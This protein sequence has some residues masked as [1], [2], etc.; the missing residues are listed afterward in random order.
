MT[1]LHKVEELPEWFRLASPRTFFSAIEVAKLFGFKSKAGLFS[2][3]RGGAFPPPDNTGVVMTPYSLKE[4]VM[5]S[6]KTILEEIKR[7]NKTHDQ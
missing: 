2:S 3:I 7:R 4:R 1:P 6:K 5:W